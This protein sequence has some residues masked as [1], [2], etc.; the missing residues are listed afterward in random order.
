MRVIVSACLLGIN[1]KYNGGNNYNQKVVDYLRDKEYLVI[2]PE[3]MA[4]LSIPRKAIEIRNGKVVDEDGIDITNNINQAN[5]DLLK[6]ID[7]FHPSLA[8]LKAKSP[9]CGYKK[10]Y[11]GSFTHTLI[12]G[13]GKSAE[14][15]HQKGIKI[16]TEEDL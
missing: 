16:L 14:L 11:D 7:T 4:G 5:C 12:Q 10:I 9:S 8:I 1:C 2:C 15:I 3:R 6:L 13:N